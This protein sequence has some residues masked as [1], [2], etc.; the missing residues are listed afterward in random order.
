MKRDSY[1]Q[2]AKCLN[3]SPSTI[4]REVKRNA[5]N[6]NEYLALEAEDGYRRR[7]EKSKRK[8]RFYQNSALIKRVKDCLLKRISPEVIAYCY[9]KAQKGRKLSG[10]TIRK[11][12]NSGF[13]KDITPRRVFRRKGIKKYKGISATIQTT[14]ELEI[15]NREERYSSRDIFGNWEA[16]TVIGKNA[17]GIIVTLVERKSRL[18]VA[19][20]CANKRADTIKLAIIDALQGLE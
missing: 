3:R 10:N 13:F 18:L 16:D 15:S 1:Q 2:I 7:R 14:P 6:R 12:V 11:A 20:Y 9:K 4:M 8:T 17:R 5:D 19:R